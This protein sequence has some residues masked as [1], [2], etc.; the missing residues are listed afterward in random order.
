M[1]KNII[2][3]NWIT[4][5]KVV[6]K[7]WFAAIGARGYMRGSPDACTYTF[8]NLDQILKEIDELNCT[9]P[10]NTVDSNHGRPN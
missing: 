7:L 9:Q 10:D 8:K 5:R 1:G 2:S 6:Q 4:D 3:L